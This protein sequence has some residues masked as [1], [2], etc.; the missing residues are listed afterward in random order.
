M[1]L[2]TEGE[3]ALSWIDSERQNNNTNASPLLITVTLRLV[4]VLKVQRSEL[5]VFRLIALIGKLIRYAAWRKSIVTASVAQR[6]K[7][8]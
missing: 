8:L 4:S 3:L 6:A 5:R 1:A 2:L 7:S